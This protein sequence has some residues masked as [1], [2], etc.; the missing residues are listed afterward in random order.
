MDALTLLRRAMMLLGETGDPLH[1]F[2]TRAASYYRHS[3]RLAPGKAEPE[4]YPESTT[5]ENIAAYRA[6][7]ESEKQALRDGLAKLEGQ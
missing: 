2:E 7:V 3:G 6:W 1:D 5:A 4:G